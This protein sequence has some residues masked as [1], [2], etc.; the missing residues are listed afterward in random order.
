MR[1]IRQQERITG[2]ANDRQNREQDDFY[3][4]PSEGVEALLSVETF[5]GPIWEC[6]CGDGAISRVLEAHGYRVISTDLVDRGY[7]QARTDFLMEWE[8]RAPN[9]VTNP[10]FKNI[11]E[12]MLQALR[13]S[14]AKVAFL[15]R[16][17]CLEGAERGKIYRSSPLARV[18]VFSNRLQIWR[19]GEK[20]SRSGGMIGFAW[21]VWDHNH[22]G[23]PT[24]GWLDARTEK[25][26]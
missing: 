1:G 9:I 3:P 11:P 21:F 20:T 25:F 17:G 2:T 13:L 26:S 14:T 24:L 4:T 12:F 15:M 10:P 18:W 5:E 19:N 6:A 22:K 16:I 7:G 23:P 8:S